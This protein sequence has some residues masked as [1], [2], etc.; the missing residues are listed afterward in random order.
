LP[1]PVIVK[2]QFEDGTDSLARFPAEIWRLNDQEIS[3][4]VTTKKKVV[5]WTL[6]PYREIA[7]ID[8]EDNAFPR[9]PA[10]PTKFQLFKQQGFQRGP[11]P[12]QQEKQSKPQSG[13]MGTGR[14]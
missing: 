7:D 6:D 3:K 2:M 5:Q 1:M 13:Q 4:V 11:N 9:Q 8:E 14:N 12:M 10:Q